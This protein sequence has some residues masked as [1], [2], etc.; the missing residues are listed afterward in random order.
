MDLGQA[1][2][3]SMRKGKDDIPEARQGE[4]FGLLLSPQLDFGVG[5]V[6][7]SLEK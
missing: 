5:D 3:V 2:A 6:L 4:E 1:K 7:L